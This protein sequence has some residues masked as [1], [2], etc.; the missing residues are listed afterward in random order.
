MAKVINKSNLDKEYIKWCKGIAR[1]NTEDE[2]IS[3]FRAH[4]DDHFNRHKNE[5]EL[6]LR[7]WLIGVFNFMHIL[8]EKYPKITKEDM[9]FKLCSYYKDYEKGAE[10][11]FDIDKFMKEYNGDIKEYYYKFQVKKQK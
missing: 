3:H 11:N 1:A 5:G 8:E 7:I 9:M 4:T 6:G 10:P 2:L